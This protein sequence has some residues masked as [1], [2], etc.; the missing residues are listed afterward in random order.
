MGFKYLQITIALILAGA[1]FLS[2]VNGEAYVDRITSKALSYTL[3]YLLTAPILLHNT[4]PAMAA[5]SIDAGRVLFEANCA[6]CHS[7]GG[8]LFDFSKTLQKDSLIKHK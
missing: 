7:G 4:F 3:R 6:S 5:D 2:S 1:C 8:N